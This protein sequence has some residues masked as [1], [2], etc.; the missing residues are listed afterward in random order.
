MAKKRYAATPV[1]RM[2]LGQLAQLT[3][4]FNPEIIKR[5]NTQ[6]HV[7]RKEYGVGSREGFKRSYRKDKTFYNELRTYLTCT[8][9]KRA[10]YV[11]F[12]GPPGKDTPVWVW[13]SCPYY[14]FNC[15]VANTRRNSS[16]I[17]LSNGQLPRERNR[18]MIPHLC[19]HLVMASRL[20]LQQRDD[21]AAERIQVEA[22]AKS[23]AATQA[24]GMEKKAREKRI[25]V[26]QFTRP[27]R[28]G[29]LIEI[30]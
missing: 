10:S 22:Q 8:D 13:C 15:E 30:P 5:A 3:A 1:N 16:S 26:K 9:G 4:R 6:C 11:R 23:A 14:T 2:T 24:A 21:L 20:A 17:K 28:S 18:Q 29:G 27:P 19:K 12:F 7:I 25:P